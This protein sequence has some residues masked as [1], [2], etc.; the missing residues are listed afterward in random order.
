MDGVG[1]GLAENLNADNIL[2]GSASA[3]E[4]G[5]GAEFLGAIFDLSD[6]ADADLRAAACADDDFAELFGGSNAAEGA[7]GLALAGQ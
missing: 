1:A 6:V 7:G 4:S 2:A 3:I 5:P